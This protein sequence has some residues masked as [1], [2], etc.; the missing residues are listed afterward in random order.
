[1]SLGA[2]RIPVQ[3]TLFRLHGCFYD[4]EPGWLDEPKAVH[5]RSGQY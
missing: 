2:T 3:L 5:N 4:D 1:M